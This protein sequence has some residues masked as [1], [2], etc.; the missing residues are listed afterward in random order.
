MGPENRAFVNDYPYDHDHYWSYNHD[1]AGGS[2]T[3]DVDVNDVDCACAAGVFAVRLDYDQCTWNAYASGTA[4]DCPTVDLM[5]A[6]IN[7]FNT[8]IATC[9]DGNCELTCD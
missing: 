3:F 4:P 6:N 5:N 8:Q 7:G 1:F 9:P 2:L